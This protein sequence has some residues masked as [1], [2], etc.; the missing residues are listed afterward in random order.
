VHSPAYEPWSSGDGVNAT[1]DKDEHIQNY[2][3]FNSDT[4]RDRG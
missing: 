3:I 4:G 1:N 2:E